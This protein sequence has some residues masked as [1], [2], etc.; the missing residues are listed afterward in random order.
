ME[1][2]PDHN[3]YRLYHILMNWKR[4]T[5]DLQAPTLTGTHNH[6]SEESHRPGANGILGLLLL[7][8]IIISKLH[9]LNDLVL[10]GLFGELVTSLRQKSRLLP[11][12]IQITASTG[13]LLCA[14]TKMRNDDDDILTMAKRRP[15]P[16]NDMQSANQHVTTNRMKLSLNHCNRPQLQNLLGDARFMAYSLKRIR[17][18]HM[19]CTRLLH[20]CSSREL[21][22]SPAW[23]RPYEW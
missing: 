17:K 11:C 8:I 2:N 20:P 13:M 16:V 12:Y 14:V 22:P 5:C 6:E 3:A 7:G 19:C 18:T 10:N 21:P 23:E 4:A 15:S 1:Q 9:L